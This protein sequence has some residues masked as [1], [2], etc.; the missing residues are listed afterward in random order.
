M[1]AV[2]PFGNAAQGYSIVEAGVH[3]MYEGGCVSQVLWKRLTISDQMPLC[4][5]VSACSK[6]LSTLWFP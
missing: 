6:V 2:S 3:G 5:T 4:R 1:K